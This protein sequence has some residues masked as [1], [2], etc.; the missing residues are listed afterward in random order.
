MKRRD[1]ERFLRTGENITIIMAVQKFTGMLA[2]VKGDL[3]RRMEDG[4]N[5]E[6]FD[7]INRPYGARRIRVLRKE[8]V[9]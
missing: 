5:I 6:A 3:L 4:Q 7:N 9:G 1:F 8:A 2:A